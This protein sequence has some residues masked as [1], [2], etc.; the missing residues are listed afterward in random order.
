MH[1]SNIDLDN[2]LGSKNLRLSKTISDEKNYQKVRKKKL[3][4]FFITPKK[5]VTYAYHS[6]S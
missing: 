1:S 6:R 4:F 3:Q 2:D 5:L